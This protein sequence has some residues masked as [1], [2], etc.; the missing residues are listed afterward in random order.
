MKKFRT[1]FVAIATIMLSFAVLAGGT[2]ALFTEDHKITNHMQA[3]TLKID[4]TRTRLRSTVLDNKGDLVVVEDPSAVPFSGKNY[5]AE[6]HPNLFDIDESVYLVPS[7]W[8]EA[9]LMI[10]NNSN[11]AFTSSVDIVFDDLASKNA[12]SEQLILT[13]M[14][15]DGTIKDS[16]KLSAVPEGGL[17]LPSFDTVSSRSFSFIVKIEFE[18][19]EN[20]VN[21][22]AQGQNVYFDLVVKATQATVAPDYEYVPVNNNNN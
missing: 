12:L 19:L 21:N 11:I 4:L 5:N 9:T 15:L 10:T 17:A 7:C 16:R 14:D 13:V 3:G 22:K 6:E 18:N 20:T 8:Y 1:L 2:F